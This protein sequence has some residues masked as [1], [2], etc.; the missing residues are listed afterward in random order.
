[1]FSPDRLDRYGDFVRKHADQSGYRPRLGLHG[2]LSV[3]TPDPKGITLMA[4]NPNVNYFSYVDL[5]EGILDWLKDNEISAPFPIAPDSAWAYLERR[6]PKR[7]KFDGMLV[8]DGFVNSTVVPSEGKKAGYF[9]SQAG[10]ELGVPLVLSA[11]EFVYFASNSS[12]EHKFDSMWKVLG[13]PHSSM[14][15]I[16][17]AAV[18]E[19]VEFLVKNKGTHRIVNVK[20]KLAGSLSR[21]VV[22]HTLE[23]LG[24]AGIIM[25][26]S[27][28]R[29]EGGVWVKGWSKYQLIDPI[30]AQQR[31]AVYQQLRGFSRNFS[32]RGT[33]NA[34]MD[35][36]LAHPDGIFE[37]GNLSEE[38]SLYPTN[39]RMTLSLLKKAKVLAGRDRSGVSAND[40]TR[41]FYE[42]VLVPAKEM[43]QTLTPPK[44]KPV[45]RRYV[46]SFLRN[47]NEESSFEIGGGEQIRN[48]IKEILADRGNPMQRDYI[49]EQVIEKTGRTVTRDAIVHQLQVLINQKELVQPKRGYYDFA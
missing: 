7:K 13:P 4:M 33:Y 25:R 41:T 19:V 2:L 21:A 44:A 23:D 15:Q 26:D 12:F 49:Y 39:A 3:L 37:A 48:V 24:D 46:N 42:M 27:P 47:Y 20:N 14:G 10:S 8:A 35:H 11:C 40:L 36:I 22:S 34:V 38:Y 1:M 28:H 18:F 5:S 31:E 29:T 17:A 43:A 45:D 9:R 32:S 30:R 16:R 6:V